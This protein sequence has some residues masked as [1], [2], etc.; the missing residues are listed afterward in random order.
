MIPRFTIAEGDVFIPEI[1]SK[2]LLIAREAMLV[3]SRLV[4]RYDEDAADGGDVIHIDQISNLVANAKAANTSVTLQAPTETG[5]DLN[6]NRHF[7]ASILIEDRIAKQAKRA[8]SLLQKYAERAGYAVAKTQDSDLAGLYSSL[9]QSVGSGSVNLTDE[10][11]LRANQYLDDAEAPEN[12]RHLVIKP[13][14]KA[15]LLAIDKFTL[16]HNVGDANAIRKAAI[17]DLYG[18]DVWTTT[19]IKVQAATPNVVHNLLF[20]REAF[21]LAVQMQPRMQ[22]QYKQEYLGTLA[23][24]DS[25]WGFGVQRNDHAVDVRCAE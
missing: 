13:A 25:L 19:Q 17:G 8:Y 7:E 14:G 16:Y 18:F 23:T 4:D 11:L 10:N 21:A 1:W 24:A 20:H 12:D 15:D 9:T 22:F 2:D 3:L 6:L 5:V